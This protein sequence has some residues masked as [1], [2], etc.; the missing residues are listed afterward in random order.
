MIFNS[1]KSFCNAIYIL[2]TL[3]VVDL[4]SNL[5][6]RFGQCTIIILSYKFASKGYDIM[7]KEIEDYATKPLQEGTKVEVSNENYSEYI[8]MHEKSTDYKP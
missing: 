8:K 4:K 2:L 1:R 3:F 7:I 5:L 6:K